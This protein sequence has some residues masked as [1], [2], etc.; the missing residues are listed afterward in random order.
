MEAMMMKMAECASEV[1]VAEGLERISCGKTYEA[2]GEEKN[3]SESPRLRS[4]MHM[5]NDKRCLEMLN[6]TLNHPH[7]TKRSSSV[8]S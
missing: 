6:Q 1:S 3:E 5:G 8:I 4:F 7:Q 2:H